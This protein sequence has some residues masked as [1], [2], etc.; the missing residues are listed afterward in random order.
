MSNV[1]M[2]DWVIDSWLIKGVIAK[3]LGMHNIVIQIVFCMEGPSP[4]QVVSELDLGR[5]S[6]LRSSFS[7]EF[8]VCDF[9]S[10]CTVFL[11]L[12]SVSRLCFFAW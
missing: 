10:S 11:K 9:R 1:I 7:I 12:S 8:V 4:P 5:E 3:P 6:S 2:V